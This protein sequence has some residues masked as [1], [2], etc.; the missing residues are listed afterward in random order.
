LAQGGPGSLQAPGKYAKRCNGDAGHQVECPT[1]LEIASSRRL[2]LHTKLQS[3]DACE[4]EQE[5]EKQAFD[6]SEKGKKIQTTQQ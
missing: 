5:Y 6:P 2:Q 1:P 4:R 3:R